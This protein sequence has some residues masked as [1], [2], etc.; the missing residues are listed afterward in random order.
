MTQASANR[1]IARAAGMVMAAYI[2]SSLTGLVRQILVT[3]AF[4]AGDALD[5][6]TSANRVSETLFNLIAG[7]AL[8]SA[9]VPVFAA[10]LTRED[11]KGAWKLAS[12]LLNIIFLAV[13]LLAVIA[14]FAAPQVVQYAL[15]SGFSDRPEQFA[16]TVKLLRLMLPSAVIFAISGLSMSILNSH[17]VFLVPALTPSMYQLGLIFGVTVLRPWGIEGLA[18]GVLIG[19]ALHLGLQIPSLL[20]LKPEYGPQLGLERPEVRQVL[21]LMLPRMFGVAVVQ[22]NFWVNTNLASR[23]GA[24][25]VSALT[26]GF[27]LM[28]MVQAAIAQSLA[29]AALPTFSAQIARGLKNEMRAS[30]ANTLRWL[31]FLSLPASFGM[32]LLARPLVALLYQRGSF[33]PEDTQLVA[34]AF[35]WYAAGLVGHSMVEILSRAFYALQDTRTPVLVGIGAM[36]LNVGFS[37]LFSRL[38][39]AVGWTPL[40]G[41]ALAN[42]SATALEMVAL[43]I[44]MRRRLNGLDGRHVLQAG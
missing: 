5:A 27:A 26:L 41:L 22:L 7:G 10:Y 38:F 29:T 2:L 4:G 13:S 9:F 12:S 39:S 34:W 24:G 11:H 30:L 37:I 44:L 25:N 43:L 35:A 3:H 8:S 31:L 16:L 32:I 33:S 6:F 20:R 14:A 42:S 18:W 1:Q 28:L 19:S 17:Q 23:M 36:S 40:G 21:R 15:A